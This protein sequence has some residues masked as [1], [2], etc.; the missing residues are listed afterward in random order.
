M[1][2]IGAAASCFGV[3]CSGCSGVTVVG[4]SPSSVDSI[5]IRACPT[6]Q[7]SSSLNEMLLTIPVQVDG[8]LATSLSVKTSTKSSNYYVKS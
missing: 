6:R 3:C 4:S 7:T 2:S 5:S 8:I 1:L